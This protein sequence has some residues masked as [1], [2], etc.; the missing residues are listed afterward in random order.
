M[1]TRSLPPV[2][3][4]LQAPLYASIPDSKNTSSSVGQW[5]PSDVYT[6]LA[7]TSWMTDDD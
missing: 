1:V 5:L 4:E 7:S 6:A 2:S 3:W